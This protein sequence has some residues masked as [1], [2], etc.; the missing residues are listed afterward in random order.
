MNDNNKSQFLFFQADDGAVHVNVL[1][2]KETVWLTQAAMAELFD[3]SPDNI[4][5]HLKNIHETG[6]LNP[7]ATTEDFSVVRKEGSR[8][9]GSASAKSAFR[10]G[11][12]IRKSRTFTS[13]ALITT[14]RTEKCRT[15][16]FTF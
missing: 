15:P 13:P 16:H 6:E 14:R 5:L 8:H 7:D 3:C 9:C 1:L 11:F 4:S 10:N 12:F 2:E